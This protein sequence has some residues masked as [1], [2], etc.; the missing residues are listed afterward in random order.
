M[1]QKWIAAMIFGIMFLSWSMPVSAETET[2]ELEPVVVTAT[3]TPE[4]PGNVT[5]KIS[6]VTEQDIEK[7]VSGNN[8]VAELL[9][10][11]PGISVNVLSR[12]DANW[13][14]NGGLSQKYNTIMLDGLPVDTFVDP[15]SL[16]PMAFKQMEVQRGPA[17]VLYPG[18]LSM[19]F[20][21]NQSPLTGT[22]NIILKEKIDQDATSA[23]V[24]LGSYETYGTRLY[25]QQKADKLHLFFGATQEDSN[26]TDYGTKNSWLNM[27]DD[28]E[29]QKTKMYWKSTYFFDEDTDHKVSLFAHRTTHD[30]DAGRP[31]RD[32]DHEYDTINTGYHLPVNPCL[33]ADFKLGYRY[34]DRTW[35]DDK[36]PDLSFASESQVKQTIVPADLSF[37]YEHLENSLL[38]VGNDFQDAKY[39]T[40]NETDQKYK[41]NDGDALLYGLYAQ[42]EIGFDPFIFRLGGRYAYTKHD[43]NLLNGS[44]PGNDSQSWN[45]WLWSAGVK[46]N[47]SR[48]VALYTNAGSSFVAPSLKSIGGTLSIDDIYVPGKNGHLPNPDLQ[49]EKGTAYDLGVEFRPMSNLMFGVRGFYNLVD[50]QIVQVVVSENPSQSQDINAGDT[51]S[52][53]AEVEA[54]HRPLQWLGLFGNYT[55]T[56]TEID[57]DEDPDQDGAE[58][59]FVPEHMGNAGFDL[60]LPYDFTAS[61][62]LHVSGSIYDSTSKQGRTKFD[63]YEVLNAS[64]NKGIL[65][66]PACRLDGYVD[67]YNLT[68]NEYEMPWQFQDPGTSVTAGIKA[69]F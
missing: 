1:K 29:Y 53:G 60:Y 8:N 27:V 52:Y 50:D 16:D 66:T 20:A 21:G 18:Y 7:I 59:P 4:S 56:D 41:G 45:K 5:Q 69:T 40:F 33:N 22:T 64:L 34:Y 15:Q 2:V 35:E 19:D 58:V 17:A 11:Q 46:Y 24:Y 48:E 63:S 42:E 67:V 9:Q 12:N 38:T 36:Y 68:N 39:Q 43:I 25:H 3:K 32:F 44:E 10:Y 65:D 62:Y 51:T 6:I 26:Y 31:N 37:A 57:N 55:Y 30:G 14:S 49:P 23:D 54:R 28:P 13:G 47:L 61:L